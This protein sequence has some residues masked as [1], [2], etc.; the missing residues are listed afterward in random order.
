MEPIFIIHR[1]ICHSVAGGGGGRGVRGGREGGGV[2][3]YHDCPINISVLLN[4]FYV[5]ITAF[6]AWS[7]VHVVRNGPNSV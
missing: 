2:T 4:R 5:W 6:F 3:F 7:V 1:F